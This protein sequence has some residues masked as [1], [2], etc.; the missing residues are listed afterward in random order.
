[1]VYRE[2]LRRK[3]N[4]KDLKYSKICESKKKFIFLKTLKNFL[5]TLSY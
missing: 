3:L 5:K 1:M 4:F 2:T